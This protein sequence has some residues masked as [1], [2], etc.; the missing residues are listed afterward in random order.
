MKG[1][2]WW[3]GPRCGSGERLCLHVHL[4]CTEPRW[5]AAKQDIPSD[6]E[7]W[8]LHAAPCVSVRR[9]TASSSWRGCWT[10]TGDCADPS[11]CRCMMT[12]SGFAPTGG[13]VEDLRLYV[14]TVEKFFCKR[15]TNNLPSN[16]KNTAGQM[17][18]DR[19]SLH[20][21]QITSSIIFWDTYRHFEGDWL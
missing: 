3:K 16:H 18:V 1:S 4:T 17:L 8:S 7:D 9:K 15:R 19:L 5:Q 6:R 13:T 10:S 14:P 11:D 12:T 21:A 20:V 2:P